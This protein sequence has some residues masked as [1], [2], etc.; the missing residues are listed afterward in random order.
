MMS[1][2]LTSEQVDRFIS[3]GFVPVEEAFPAGVAAACRDLL[4][5]QT[6]CDPADPA[7]WTRPVIRIEAMAQQ[8]F[9][10][11]ATTPRLHAAFDQLVGTGRWVPRGGLGTFPRHPQR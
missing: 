3:D 6:G 1:E 5:A 8:P 11:V 7:T 2:A 10:S 9:R 4:W